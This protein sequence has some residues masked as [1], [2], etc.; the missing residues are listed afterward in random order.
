M[1]APET[2]DQ[3]TYKVCGLVDTLR[4]MSH[5]DNTRAC[6]SVNITASNDLAKKL[7]D[8]LHAAPKAAT[9]LEAQ[10]AELAAATRRAERALAFI[11]AAEEAYW[12]LAWS[13]QSHLTGP[14]R[15]FDMSIFT[16]EAR[17]MMTKAEQCLFDALSEI[18]P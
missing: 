11:A 7:F 2:I 1:S 8:V 4:S 17:N 15:P 18:E 12:L 3:N 14:A 10:A 13:W 9:A 16:P 5:D 6:V